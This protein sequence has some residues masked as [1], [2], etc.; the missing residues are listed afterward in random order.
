MA[1]DFNNIYLFFTVTENN[2]DIKWWSPSDAYILSHHTWFN[3]YSKI[4]KKE[5][6]LYFANNTLIRSQ[7]GIVVIEYRD[8]NKCQVIKSEEFTMPSKSVRIKTFD[9]NVTIFVMD[10]YGNILKK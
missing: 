2:K 8:G 5:N 6:I 7:F 9:T 10:L 1:L 3:H 4:D